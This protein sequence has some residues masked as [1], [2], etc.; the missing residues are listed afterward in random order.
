[1]YDGGSTY[2]PSDATQ[3]I[4]LCWEAVF[5]GGTLSTTALCPHA[6]SGIVAP[7]MI[8]KATEYTQVYVIGYREK[9]E[10]KETWFNGV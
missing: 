9:A 2:L 1:M 8:C 10:T 4:V 7:P 5:Q 3:S 6:A